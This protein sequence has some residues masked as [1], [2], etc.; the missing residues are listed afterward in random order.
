MQNIFTA[1]IYTITIIGLEPCALNPEFQH[2]ILSFNKISL[3][4]EYHLKRVQGVKAGP[5]TGWRQGWLLQI[6]LLQ[7]KYRFPH[8][9][10]DTC[11]RN[12]VWFSFIPML[13]IYGAYIL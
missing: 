9:K 10:H 12:I 13:N 3:L 7:A 5:K 8:G 4:C 1:P 2:F 11:V 6:T